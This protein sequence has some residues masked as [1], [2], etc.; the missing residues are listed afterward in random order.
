M[1]SSSSRHTVVL[2]ST[3]TCQLTS[4]RN[5][6]FGCHLCLLVVLTTSNERV[7]RGRFFQDSR[8]HYEWNPQENVV[9]SDAK[10]KKFLQEF[11]YMQKFNRNLR[12]W[13][14][15]DW[16]Y[17][18]PKPSNKD[19]YDYFYSESYI[20]EDL[21]SETELENTIDP[22]SSNNPEEQVLFKEAVK[23]FQKQNKLPVS[24]QVDKQT[25]QMFLL[26]RC[27][28]PDNLGKFMIKKSAIEK[29]KSDKPVIPS[30]RQV[31]RSSASPR[32]IDSTTSSSAESLTTVFTTYTDTATEIPS[33]TNTPVRRKRSS[34]FYEIIKR[35]K[36]SLGSDHDLTIEANTIF[37]SNV[38][39]WRVYSSSESTGIIAT[40]LDGVRDTM[41]DAFRM[42]AEITPLI[43]VENLYGDVL[44]VDIGITFTSGPHSDGHP[45]AQDDGSLNPTVYSHVIDT[46]IHFNNDV[47]FTIASNQ[48]ISLLKTAVH[49]IGHVL[50]L[51]H[52]A[53]TQAIMYPY[54]TSFDQ[55][56]F[57]LHSSDRQDIHGI[58]SKCSGRFDS[59]VDWVRPKAGG[60][61]RVYTTY[62][63]NDSLTWIYE[64]KSN[65]TRDGEPRPTSSHWPGVPTKIDAVL[66]I[67]KVDNTLYFFS[68]VN[69]TIY[70]YN[71]VSALLNRTVDSISSR[72]P[73]VP[74][75]IDTA[76]VDKKDKNI[77]FFKGSQVYVFDVNSHSV[78][79]GYPKPINDVYA[80]RFPTVNDDPL[81]SNFDA[82]YY[83]QKH[84]TLFF[85]KGDQYWRISYHRKSANV[86]ERKFI[87]PKDWNTYWNDICE[88]E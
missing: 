61:S 29:T 34:S 77:Y 13:E 68:G 64:N 46:G 32:T 57:G 47:H 39:S 71:N 50:G 36:R 87:R 6:L 19:S 65:K 3:M 25:M 17:D 27:G 85:F 60:T 76:H 52:S 38:V 73:G 63:F 20:Y 56:N 37:P 35:K 2:L 15:T 70:F 41:K 43:F 28:V 8:S 40:D 69:V 14:F 48:G 16:K 49:E 4:I 78:I 44:N 83:S 30:L 9:I 33:T 42:W 26:P 12:K 88:V 54:Y 18:G 58:Y 55:N 62:F 75:N 86:Y 45:F 82:T 53:N 51:N 1:S 74:D 24:G 80:P 81:P 5:L 11:G 10:A 79:S 7:H 72:F 22:E 66:Q 59:I 84:R 21:G 31:Q 67:R 23:R